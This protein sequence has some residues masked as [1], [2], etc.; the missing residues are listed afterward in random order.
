MKFIKWTSILAFLFILLFGAAFAYLYNNQDQLRGTLTSVL[1]EKL[2]A[3]IDVKGIDLDLFTHF[4]DVSI[5]FDDVFCKEVLPENSS[6]TLFQFKSIHFRFQ[7]FDVLLGKYEVKRISFH[8]GN[9]ELRLYGDGTDNFH[10]W[11]ESSDTTATSASLNLNA[12]T[13]SNTKFKM[14]NFRSELRIK[15][16][17]DEFKLSGIFDKGRF[18]ALLELD[19]QMVSMR[20]EG[21]TLLQRTPIHAHVQFGTDGDVTVF[22][23][24]QLVLN[25]LPLIVKGRITSDLTTWSI[26]G[27][28]LSFAEFIRL[29]PSNYIPDQELV[30]ASGNFNLNVNLESTLKGSLINASIAMDNAK[31]D[32]NKSGLHFEKLRLRAGFSNGKYGRLEDAQLHVSEFSA[33]TKTGELKG[34]LKISNFN[35]P[36]IQVNGQVSMDLEEALSIAGTTFQESASGRLEGDFSIG[37]RFP[38]FDA[39]QSEG[40]IK[41]A[42]TGNLKLTNG[43]LKVANSTLNMQSLNGDLSINAPNLI[44]NNI[45][46]TSD[47]S[48][49]RLSGKIFNALTFEDKI[50]PSFDINLTSNVLSLDEILG[51]NFGES[52]ESGEPLDWKAN[53][54]LGKFTHGQFVANEVKGV[55]WNEGVNIYGSQISLKTASGMASGR[56]AW[57]PESDLIHFTTTISTNQIELKALFE[58]FN[59]FGQSEITSNQ[60]SGILNSDI[61]VDLYFDQNF[62]PQISS[63]K[64]VADFTI[65]NG[66]LKGY[67]PLMALS[68]FAEL[69][70]LKDVRFAQLKNTITIENQIIRIPGMDIKSNV[71]ELW[72][73]GTHSFDNVVDYSLKLKLNDVLGKKNRT[74]KSVSEFIVEEDTRAQPIIP[75]KINGKIGNL[76][77]SIDKQLLK[78]GLKKEWEEQGNTLKKLF[79][80]GAPEKPKEKTPVYLFEW[81]EADTTGM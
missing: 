10:F 56:F 11:K 35:R 25:D 8:D 43:H 70:D 30:K 45:S 50:R 48:D 7:L 55:F 36:L 80:E 34:T 49:F 18:D 66:R 60:I 29:M 73:Q 17:L 19:G 12:V 4:P 69:D 3:P 23:D 74:N 52:K 59:N 58:E 2:N 38:A 64:T 24:G 21:Q 13:F 53:V 72:M 37:K 40:M 14:E 75:I 68:D 54:S 76:N 6:D 32:L 62:N 44:I 31:L 81:E 57:K 9:I 67:E 33:A 41:A 42:F 22:E 15:S 28:Q 16:E 47:A 61:N 5:R 77:I 39:I 78:E 20:S 63:L 26:V 79:K 46:F 27:E 51:W 1:N 71:W 65:N